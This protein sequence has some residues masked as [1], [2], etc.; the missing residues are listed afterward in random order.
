MPQCEVKNLGVLFDQTLSMKSHVSALCRRAYHELHGINCLR[1]S[2][3]KEAAAAAVHAFVT[4][5]IDNCNALLYGIPDCT[6][7]K[8]QK[9]QNAAAR[10]LTG[11]RKTQHIKPVLKSLHWLPVCYHGRPRIVYKILVIVYKC[12]YGNGPEYLKELLVPYT[13]SRTLRSGTDSRLLI[14][15]RTRLATGGDRS[16]QKAGPLLWNSLPRDIRMSNSLC[17][18]KSKLKKYLYTKAFKA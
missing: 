5:R 3:N 12:L 9:V 13:P 17:Q 16:F 1:G 10:T 2:L 15:P 11:G 14:E 7:M 6:L 18:F 8:V 4:S